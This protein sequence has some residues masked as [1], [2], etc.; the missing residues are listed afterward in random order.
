MVCRRCQCPLLGEVAQALR[1]NLTERQ[2]VS[3]LWIVNAFLGSIAFAALLFFGFYLFTVI[4]GAM[5]SGETGWRDYTPEQMPMLKFWYFI[6]LGAGVA[7]IILF[8]F[9]RRHKYNL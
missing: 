5:H 9:S 2:R 8:F 4:P 3:Y 7:F 6:S 1:A